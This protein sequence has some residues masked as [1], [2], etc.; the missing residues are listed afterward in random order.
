VQPSAAA[1]GAAPQRPT[2]INDAFA[3]LQQPGTI[4]LDPANLGVTDTHGAIALS[5]EVVTL[6]PQDQR[7]L[8]SLINGAQLAG[9]GGTVTVNKFFID[10]LTLHPQIRPDGS[11]DLNPTISD[12]ATLDIPLVGEGLKALKQSAAGAVRPLEDAINSR[13]R[14]AGLRARSLKIEAGKLTI[15]SERVTAA[16]TTTATTTGGPP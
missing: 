9:T 11:V 15:E 12:D 10:V 4:E 5:D 16:G 8:V 1:A 7:R 13:L 6:I 2:T 3:S 14:D